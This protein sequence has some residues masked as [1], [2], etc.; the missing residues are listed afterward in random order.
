[1][2]LASDPVGHGHGATRGVIAQRGPLPTRSFLNG[3]G[4]GGSPSG[5]PR[6]VVDDDRRRDR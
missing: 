3:N 1:M 6:R 5:V 4:R 2:R